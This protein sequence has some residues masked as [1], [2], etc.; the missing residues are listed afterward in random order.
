M[1]ELS[2]QTAGDKGNVL[3]RI[4]KTISE[5]T[6]RKEL[7]APIEIQI[8]DEND[9]QNLL[10]DKSRNLSS[11][12]GFMPF[13]AEGFAEDPERQQELALFLVQKLALKN[14]GPSLDVGFGKN[15]YISETFINAGIKASAI[16]EMQNDLESGESMIHAPRKKRINENGVEIFSGDIAELDEKDSAL[17]G[18]K[19]G[20]IL[21]NGSWASGGNNFTVAGEVM[22]SK[23]HDKK[24]KIESMVEFMDH[25]KDKILKSCRDHLSTNGLIGIVSSRYAFHGAGYDYS[26]LP[27]EKLSFIDAYDRFQGLHAK[28]V[29]LFG[30]T[31]EGF[32]QMLVRST[33][34][35]EPQPDRI[36]S[37]REQLRRI[38]NLPQA[39]VYSQFGDNPD[40]Q[41]S[42]IRK[43]I[44]STRSI[45]EFNALARI[46]AVFAEF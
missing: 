15:I 16:D 2:G 24:D 30:V 19:F 14:R 11:Q 32:D 44:E 38:S 29:Y 12:L 36:K 6:H 10:S 41:K 26:Q 3:K 7:V 45:P 27:D 9:P 13:S 1:S 39:D 43:A 40:Y 4:I 25:E 34:Q 23:Y 17:K 31:Q 22:E 33:K 5:K 21:F 42:R 28:K 35:N 18:N 37:V 46:D 20:L 8:V